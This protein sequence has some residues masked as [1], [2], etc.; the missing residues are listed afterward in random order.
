MQLK[1][2]ISPKIIDFTYNL[3]H[4]NK[5]MSEQKDRLKQEF[6]KLPRSL[7]KIIQERIDGSPKGNAMQF[8]DHLDVTGGGKALKQIVI[9]PVKQDRRETA[10]TLPDLSRTNYNTLQN[11]PHLIATSILNPMRLNPINPFKSF[12][13]LSK[14]GS[15]NVMI[16]S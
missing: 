11:S 12:D 6:E 3:T 9:N 16:P 10:H 4:D 2:G 15:L 1:Q 8:N 13:N 7:L 5:I 14:A